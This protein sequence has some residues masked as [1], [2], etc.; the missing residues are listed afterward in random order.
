MAPPV[1]I[2]QPRT[3]FDLHFS[4]CPCGDEK[5]HLS[6]VW[7]AVLPQVNA[8]NPSGGSRAAG[9]FLPFFFLRLS[10]PLFSLSRRR[11]DFSSI[12]HCSAGSEGKR[13][14]AA[15][16]SS[17]LIG[18]QLFFRGVILSRLCCFH[19]CI[20]W[21]SSYAITFQ[22]ACVVG[23]CEVCLGPSESTFKAPGSERTSV[24]CHSQS[25]VKSAMARL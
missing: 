7:L 20:I 3:R 6:A 4:N 9:F 25:D 18:R 1:I 22:P 13:D 17:P 14:A 16:G 23:F 8:I 11:S 19:C 5:P 12:R 2:Y 21:Q 24:S 10:A 15:V